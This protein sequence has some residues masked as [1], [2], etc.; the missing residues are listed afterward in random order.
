MKWPIITMDV[1][2]HLVIPE[3]L[4]DAG[5]RILDSAP[6]AMEA[7]G[8][9]YSRYLVGGPP[10]DEELRPS[11][12]ECDDA[13]N[14]LGGH[15]ILSFII[16]AGV[17]RGKDAA[18]QKD[19][20]ARIDAHFALFKHLL[21]TAKS[22][23]EIVALVERARSEPLPPFISTNFFWA[24]L[25]GRVGTARA[26]EKASG[27][28]VEIPTANL[29]LDLVSKSS[30]PT[31]TAYLIEAGASALFVALLESHG[32]QYRV[33]DAPA[34]FD[35]EPCRLERIEE[36]YDEVYQ[37]YENRTIVAREPLRQQEFPA[38]TLIVPLAQPLARRAV[39]V[40]EPSMFHGIYGYDA[41]RPL[42]Q[43]GKELPI[44]RVFPKQK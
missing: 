34:Q 27:R 4:R 26:V 18:S 37:R 8:H 2:N 30:A 23:A 41:F 44:F 12:T 5:Q 17:M 36:P 11:T 33:L 9:A 6:K 3:Y 20:G 42:A 16:E 22:R 29:T 32:L 31:P 38:G 40:L 1:M 43:E 7:A 15:C 24:N 14:G 25:G 10:P 19:L 28:M 21:G 35:V 39:Q 13:R